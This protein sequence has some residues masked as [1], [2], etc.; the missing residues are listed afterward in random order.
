MGAILYHHLTSPYIRLIAHYLDGSQG[1]NNGRADAGETINL[2]VTLI[3]T[4]L[5]A[6]RI[7]ATLSTI[8]TGVQMVNVN[9][10]FGNMARND[11]ADNQNNPFSFFVIPSSITHPS[12][13][14]LNITSAGG[15]LI[16]DSL[17]IL[18]GTPVFLLVD[19]DGG[20]LYEEQYLR[21]MGK[22]QTFAEVWDVSLKSTPTKGELDQYKAVIWYTGDDQVNTLTSEEQAILAS[23]LDGGGNLFLTGQNIG[24]DLVSTGSPADSVF[25][26]ITFML[27]ICLIVQVLYLRWE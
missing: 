4:S 17:K 19:D 16:T 14:Y 13:F 2:I 22:N 24:Y 9:V 27:N 15:Y 1:N 5:D 23:Y 18:I 6:S 20:D 10:D 25:V 12:T 7:S 11:S 21:A 3:N 26:L 8:D